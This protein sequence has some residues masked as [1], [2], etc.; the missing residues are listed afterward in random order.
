MPDQESDISAKI[1]A[2]A[3]FTGKK[4]FNVNALSGESYAGGV[5]LTVATA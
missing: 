5:T 3:G 1:T 4:K 2:P